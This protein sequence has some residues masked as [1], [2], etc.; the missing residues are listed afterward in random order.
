MN[1]LRN[2][3][4]VKRAKHL[5]FYECPISCSDERNK[6]LTSDSIQWIYESNYSDYTN[7]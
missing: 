7:A 3:R 4:P 1:V 2:V 6:N 5:E